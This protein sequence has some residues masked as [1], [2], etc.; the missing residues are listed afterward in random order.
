[1]APRKRALDADGDT[2]QPAGKRQKAATTTDP[3]HNPNSA[4]SE[5][6]WPRLK[7]RLKLGPRMSPKAKPKAPT[8]LSIPLEMQQK[9]LMYTTARDTTRL[10]RVCKSL[11]KVS[12]HPFKI[13]EIEAAIEAMLS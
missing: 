7:L 2:P 9:I 4:T 6:V 1:M 3:V 13:T 8:L 5:S 11:N 10:R 12:G